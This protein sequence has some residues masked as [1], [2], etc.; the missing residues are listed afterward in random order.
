[1]EAPEAMGC[2]NKLL[3]PLL[4]LLII[5]TCTPPKGRAEVLYKRYY[6][7][8]VNGRDVL[9]EPY[10]VR[11]NDYVIK[12]LKQ[13]GEISHTNFP[14]F[15]NIFKLINHHIPDINRIHP[16]QRIFVPL[17]WLEPDALP[18]Q[19]RGI[20]DL[21]FITAAPVKQ[22]LAQGATTHKV[23]P[24]DSVSRIISNQFGPTGSRTYRE[25]VKLFRLVN[26]TVKDLNRIYI[27]Q[28]L[29]V[30]DASVLDEDWY[31]S[32]FEADGEVVLQATETDPSPAEEAG[33]TQYEN[34]EKTGKK[35]PFD[36]LAKLLGGVLL[37][38]GRYYFPDDKGNDF[39][40]NL[41]ETPILQLPEG[42]RILFVHNGL[43]LSTGRRHI[44]A[45]HFK[46][47]RFTDT[48]LE[49]TLPLLLDA[50]QL[51]YPKMRLPMPL[52]F[53]EEG[54]NLSL[55][56][57]WA[58]KYDRSK[59]KEAFR[60]IIVSD[61]ADPSRRFPVPL[62]A[63]FRKHGLVLRE[64]L[65]GE[66][67]PPVYFAT[68]K[69]TTVKRIVPYTRKIYVEKLAEALGLL[70]DPN[71]SISF[72]YAGTQLETTSNMI[73]DP[74]GAGALVDFGDLYGDAA[75][76][77]ESSGLKVVSIRKGDYLFN[78][79][80][81]LLTKLGIPFEKNPRFDFGADGEPLACALSVD[82]ILVKPA[83]LVKKLI[84]AS[85]L[86]DDIIALLEEQGLGIIQIR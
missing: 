4:V 18:G 67:L 38:R 51:A 33:V 60:G 65:Q 16:G 36:A 63:Y 31:S 15:L 21:P 47:L 34:D 11:P 3:L 70:Y 8:N 64:S 1:M 5:G 43:S 82:G 26:P 10:V 61:L 19:R 58:F 69:S 22:L 84:V 74:R 24:G 27:G 23:A 75:F 6:V 42:R 78:A 20:V 49:P 44:M 14:L 37:N 73:R 29:K 45:T 52:S 66:A 62:A 2:W 48:S 68:E 7:H 54:M 71:I 50:V 25:G 17:K 83:P 39:S 53:S 30:P 59:S 86:P 77:I 79:T 76:A 55:K 35:D 12:I 32:V 40:V 46:N 41:S 13:K 72:S 9:S 85:T 80:L 57:R 81:R 56:A 28:K